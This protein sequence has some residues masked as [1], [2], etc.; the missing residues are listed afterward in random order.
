MLKSKNILFSKRYLKFNLTVSK[1]RLDKNRR[2]PKNQ[3][4]VVVA[5]DYHK[6]YTVICSNRKL[7][8]SRIFE[9]L[10]STIVS[11]LTLVRNGEEA[12][13]KEY[14]EKTALINKIFS[15]LKRYNCRLND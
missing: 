3:L 7:S 5:I 11:G 15:W 13:D 10:M 12:Y 4:C 8:D 9:S 1:N 6:I 2:L 14:L